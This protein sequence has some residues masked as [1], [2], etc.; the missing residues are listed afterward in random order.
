MR[1]SYEAGLAR[2]GARKEGDVKPDDYMTWQFFGGTIDPANR[3]R[4]NIVFF[5]GM[6]PDKMLLI[7]RDKDGKPVRDK[8][9]RI[10]Y[11][12]MMDGMEELT[13]DQLL[14]LDEACRAMKANKRLV[15]A[16]KE[17]LRHLQ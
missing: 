8:H 4:E 11:T 7:E 9:G 5:F 17:R 12:T 1:P 10:I 2:G 15:I 13:D 3:T 14:Q 16:G 6:D